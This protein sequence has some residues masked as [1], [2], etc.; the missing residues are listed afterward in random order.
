[1]HFTKQVNKITIELHLIIIWEVKYI[2]LQFEEQM[3]SKVAPN[4]SQELMINVEKYYIV[5]VIDCI[6][7]VAILQ[8]LTMREEN[9]Q[10]TVVIERVIPEAE[11][12][13]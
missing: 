12:Q 3:G 13:Y 7:I 6:D 2:L 9:Q 5:R 8:R 10:E 4:L 1:M 11:M